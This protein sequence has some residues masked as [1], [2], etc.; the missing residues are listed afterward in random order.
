MFWRWRY[1]DNTDC[2]GLFAY[3]WL[4]QNNRRT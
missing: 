3:A 4:Q 1:T 2:G